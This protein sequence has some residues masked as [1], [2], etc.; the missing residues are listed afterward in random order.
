MSAMVMGTTSFFTKP[1]ESLAP[2]LGWAVVN[3]GGLGG[4]LGAEKVQST[5]FYC[6]VCGPLVLAT[7]QLVSWSYFSLH[8][9]HLQKI[10]E[11]VRAMDRGSDMEGGA[12]CLRGGSEE[13][14]DFGC[15]EEQYFGEKNSML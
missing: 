9:S 2:M 15:G 11:S 3:S 4:G 12:A 14:G 5:L 13:G 6:L 10:K 1:G 8:G 7:M